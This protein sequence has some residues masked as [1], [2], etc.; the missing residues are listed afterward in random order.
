MFSGSLLR[1][2]KSTLLFTVMLMFGSAGPGAQRWVCVCAATE[3]VGEHEREGDTGAAHHPSIHL[4]WAFQV[5]CPSRDL[6][7]AHK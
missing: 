5:H 4:L 3:K 7:K 6:A 2:K 1:F